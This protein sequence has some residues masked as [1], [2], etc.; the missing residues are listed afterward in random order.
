MG[1][2]VLASLRNKHPVLM[3]TTDHA[4]IIS[5]LLITEKAGTT[6]Q[7]VKTNDVYWH[8]NFGWANETTGYYQLDRES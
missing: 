2:R 1:D 7:L 8:A 3:L 5:G 6:R 4:F